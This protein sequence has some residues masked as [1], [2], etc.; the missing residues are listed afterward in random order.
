MRELAESDPLTAGCAASHERQQRSAPE[1]VF[2]VYDAGQVEDGGK[3]VYAPYQ[4]GY[5]LILRD[6]SRCV[7]DQRNV[8]ELV[9]ERVSVLPQP[10]LPKALAVIRQQHGDHI[11]AEAQRFDICE[12][13]SD[14][15]VRVS[16]V[17]VVHVDDR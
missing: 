16:D 17:P 3:Y 8:K 5:G 1:V 2:V 6:P 7:K 13:V 14:D 12:E 11:F 9:V 15:V 4:L 10:V